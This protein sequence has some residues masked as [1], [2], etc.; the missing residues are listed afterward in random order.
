MSQQGI[1]NTVNLGVWEV[2]LGQKGNVS[3][4]CKETWKSNNGE[5]GKKMESLNTSFVKI[6]SHNNKDENT[7]KE[8]GHNIGLI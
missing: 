7:T 5:H 4:R 3:Q 1:Q 8:S 6:S 2:F